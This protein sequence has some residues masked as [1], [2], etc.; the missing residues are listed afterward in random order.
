M[1]LP[2][3]L[4]PCRGSVC[5]VLLETF[6]EDFVAAFTGDG[7]TV[8]A[9]LAAAG[10]G[11]G[12]MTIV[13]GSGADGDMPLDRTAGVA[14]M[15]A[16]MTPTIS[17]DN[18]RCI[19][20]GVAVAISK[21]GGGSGGGGGGGRLVVIDS[22][23]AYMALHSASA[24][25]RAIRRL[26]ERS[27]VDQVVAVVHSDVHDIDTLAQLNHM[28][29]TSITVRETG[30]GGRFPGEAAATH[31]RRS[32]KVIAEKALYGVDAQGILRTSLVSAGADG[33]GGGG[34]GG[35]DD[36]AADPTANLSFNL[37][38]TA[39]QRKAKANVKLPYTI[40]QAEQE[41]ELAGGQTAMIHYEADD[42]DDV[43]E[44]DP[45]DDLDL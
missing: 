31:R 43:D 23:T 35:G 45:D 33:G 28:V 1:L 30:A 22:L 24:A 20:D 6:P 8:A 29:S 4:P 40:S 36:G 21:S 26:S 41:R 5:A 18:P 17:L 27:D 10:G 16:S 44:E 2:P 7:G 14:A 11:T 3:P 15:P 42:G 37:N 25:V 38:L 12:N 19:V 39:S 13:D 9:A 32:G 34:G